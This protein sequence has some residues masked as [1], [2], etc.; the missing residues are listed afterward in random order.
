[1]K[2]KAISQECGQRQIEE[3]VVKLFLTGWE[4]GWSKGIRKGSEQ[5]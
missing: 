1:M 3:D 5:S 4:S 2:S